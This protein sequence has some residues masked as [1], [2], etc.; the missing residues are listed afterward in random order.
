MRPTMRD[1]AEHSWFTPCSARRQV[2]AVCI[3]FLAFGSLSACRS[4]TASALPPRTPSQSAVPTPMPFT[5]PPEET[6]A[7]TN[8]P[9]ITA[10]TS[11]P[12]TIT[13]TVPAA[14]ATVLP[15]IAPTAVPTVAPTAPAAV[16]PLAATSAPANGAQ[17]A[18]GAAI[19]AETCSGCHGKGGVGQSGFPR[20]AGKNTLAH[21]GTAKGLFDYIKVA[22]PQD[23]PGSL[24]PDEYY[25]LTAY[26]L[27]LNGVNTD[28]Q[29][30]V[31][32]ANVTTLSFK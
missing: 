16:V 26:L 9:V 10:P 14:T 29:V 27:S 4:G 13:A 30:T 6:I 24:S 11:V 5:P 31:D 19:F 1:T 25:A 12:P 22:M 18:R 23:R 21:F 8:V 2:L 17:I 28:G 15:T 20:L 3:F 32:P 7:P